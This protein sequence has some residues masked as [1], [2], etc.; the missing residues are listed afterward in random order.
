MTDYGSL[1]RRRLLRAGVASVVGLGGVGAASATDTSGVD[2]ATLRDSAERLGPRDLSG[3]DDETETVDAASVPE[4]SSGIGPGSMLLI[5]RDGTTA[6]CT[7]NFVWEDGGAYYLGAAGHCFLADGAVGENTAPDGDDLSNVTVK[8]GVDDFTFGGFAALNG[9]RGTTYELGDV[10]Y[11]RQAADDGTQV[12]HDFGLVEIPQEAVD[13]GI[14]DPSLPQFGGPTGVVESG[15]LPSGEPICQYGNGVGNGEVFPTKGRRG[16]SLG[17]FG[18]YRSW[19]AALRGSPGD[20]GSAILGAD[21]TADPEGT[22]AAGA[23]THLTA[24][25]TAGTTIER[26]IEMANE[27]VGLNIAVVKQGDL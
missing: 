26:C 25:G 2:E 23:L 19:Y 14:V 18:D 1:S 11:A 10:V 3:L 8:V 17:D 15:A 4:R 13:A 27:D 7:A 5:E 9:L 22:V 16:A 20:S 24:Q 6:G 12:G 21:P